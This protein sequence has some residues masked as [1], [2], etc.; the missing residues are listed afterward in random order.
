MTLQLE[1]KLLQDARALIANEQNWCKETFQKHERFWR[2]R[3]YCLVGAL[4]QVAM[5]EAAAYLPDPLPVF[6]ANADARGR[7]NW[8]AYRTCGGGAIGF[9]DAPRTTHRDVLWLLDM[10]ITQC[11]QELSRQQAKADVPPAIM[12]AI[13]VQVEPH[14][15]AT[16][17]ELVAV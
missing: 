15:G 13:G 9:N 2:P 7:L 3:Q 12:D 11:K 17:R 6:Q 4:E 10:A 14:R 5:N 16:K 8:L 1:L